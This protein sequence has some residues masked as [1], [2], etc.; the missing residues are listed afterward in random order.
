MIDRRNGCQRIFDERRRQMGKEG[1]S[2]ESDVIKYAKRPG[3]LTQAA[4]C[5]SAMAS[6]DAEGR[7]FAREHPRNAISANWP[8]SE[9]FWKPG[10]DNSHESRIRELEKAGALIAAEIDRLL[11]ELNIWGEP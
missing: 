6:T 4:T 7:D 2:I 9:E 8:W 1:Y 3:E 5:Y 10:K 11:A